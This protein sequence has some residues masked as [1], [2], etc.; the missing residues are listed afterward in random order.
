MPA[1]IRRLEGQVAS[2]STERPAVHLA[3]ARLYLDPANPSPDYL[4]AL[5]ELRFFAALDPK[6]GAEP[7]VRQWIGALEVLARAREDRD[8]LAARLEDVTKES[9]EARKH[10]SSLL[11]ETQ[12]RGRAAES[13]TREEAGLRDAVRS[14]TRENQELKQQIEKL[15]ALDRQ[16]EILRK[17]VR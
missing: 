9:A 1:E 8:R 4:A 2:L 16:L 10:L 3:L 17:N 13:Q 6:G 14:L 12:E 5:A 15:K 11:R 7:E